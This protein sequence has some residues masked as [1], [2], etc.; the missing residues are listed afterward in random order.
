MLLIRTL[1]KWFGLI[2]GLQFLLWTV[3]GAMMALLDHHKVSGEHTVRAPAPLAA[4]TKLMSIGALAEMV[5]GP[6]QGVKLRPLNDRYV[7]E[8]KT[9]MG[10]SILDAVSG[11][12]MLID[13]AAARRLAGAAYV[14]E[15]KVTAV[16][17]VAKHGL[18]TRGL[19]LPLWKARFDDADNTTLYVAATTGEVVERRNDTWR[20]WDVFWMLHI[21]DYSDR[22]SFNHPLIITVATGVA[23]LALSGV[24]LLFRSFRRSDF[25]WVLDGWDRLR[26]R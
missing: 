7:Y 18:E 3:S 24:I 25:A 15:G 1:H 17:P 21:M 13:A 11:Q 2:L 6:V 26:S 8:V 22:A 4:P 5:A 14:G 16:E 20:L 9:A 10:T 12:P 23:W 19:V